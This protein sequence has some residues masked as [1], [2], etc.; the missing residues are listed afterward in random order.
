[1]KKTILLILFAF[2]FAAPTEASQ[3]VDLTTAQYLSATSPASGSDLT[4][5]DGGAFILRLRDL[6][7]SPAGDKTIM[8]MTGF[9]RVYVASGT[10]NI[11]LDPARVGEPNV[12]LAT[13]GR[14]AGFLVIGQNSSQ[15]YTPAGLSMWHVYFWD[16]TGANKLEATQ[17][18]VSKATY[19]LTS[20]AIAFGARV[21]GTEQSGIYLDHI[22]WS[23]SLWP[24]YHQH[25]VPRVPGS[26]L[27]TLYM[28]WGLESVY[29]GES[30]HALSAFSLTANGSPSFTAFPNVNPVAD[31]S[32][33]ATNQSLV[34]V[35]LDGSKSWDIDHQTIKSITATGFTWAFVSKP[36]G[37]AT[38]TITCAS[39]EVT[40]LT[41][42]DTV[43]SY[44]YSLTVTD[45]LGN[46]SSATNVS[47]TVAALTAVASASRT[48]VYV[49]EPVVF[50]SRTSAGVAQGPLSGSG[51]EGRWGAEWDFGDSR[52][53]YSAAKIPAPTHSFLTPGV[54]TVTLTTRNHNSQTAT[55]TETITVTAFP[56]TFTSTIDVASGGDI[57]A[58]IN[59]AAAATGNIR[60]RLAQGGTYTL[61]ATLQLKE[62]VD[63]NWIL[64]TS[65]GTAD[66]TW[67][68]A[69]TRVGSSESTL[70]AKIQVTSS[71]H[72]I[73]STQPGVSVQHY[74]FH[75]IEFYSSQA[76]SGLGMI[77]LGDSASDASATLYQDQQ[78][79]VPKYFIFDQCYIHAD[80]ANTKQN[81]RGFYLHTDDIAILNSTVDE[82]KST[83]QSAGIAILN[84]SGPVMVLNCYVAATG[85]NIFSGGSMPPITTAVPRY[86]VWGNYI[87][88]YDK[89]DARSGSYIGQGSGFNWDI[90]NLLEFKN[91][92]QSII[93]GNV[94]DR[95][96]VQGT[97]PGEALNFNTIIDSG[98]GRKLEWFQVSNNKF[99]NVGR[100]LSALRAREETVGIAGRWFL[101]ENDL[102]YKVGE[103]LDDPAASGHGFFWIGPVGLWLNH[104][105]VDSA[106]NPLMM[107]TSTDTADG[108]GQAGLL[109]V[110]NS[111]F[112]Y[113]ARGFFGGAAHGTNAFDRTAGEWDV[114]EVTL[115]GL[116]SDVDGAAPSGDYPSGGGTNIYT[117]TAANYSAQFTDYAGGDLSIANTSPSYQQ[118]T[119]GTS[120]GVNMTTLNAAISGAVSGVWTTPEPKGLHGGFKGRGGFKIR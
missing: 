18:V 92:E 67:P 100:G 12:T 101:F 73:L 25:P 110:V 19:D 38:P 7:T 64:I 81:I 71:N 33:T 37:A 15:F 21:G 42:V 103:I 23:K 44:T 70:M 69:N 1:M 32:A 117:V 51:Q 52:G 88:K 118:G 5:S 35:I 34:K 65:A 97:Q 36:G 66:G 80:P 109:T 11:V 29:T 119:D 78:S 6:P 104:V 2:L 14:T 10:N 86:T 120:H 68:A 46:A 62:K 20:K 113:G 75:G 43:G 112:R 50:E 49:G 111:H 54:Y 89:W 16:E 9:M 47:V 102:F 116:D 57:Q 28:R 41:G 76:S 59:T 98:T 45:E 26:P 107:T 17:A 3:G 39:C 22:D 31:P 84:G 91:A 95:S 4:T 90:E 114:R 93:D 77:V 99:L 83:S 63:A 58:A 48:S 94:F 55:D 85:E 79:K 115:V 56:T 108:G 30:G 61:G 8:E 72:S 60:I 24:A 105:T 87:V 96:W 74:K 82:I 53:S 27:D 40:T 106:G 13:G